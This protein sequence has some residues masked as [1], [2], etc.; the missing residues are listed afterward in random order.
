MLR[1]GHENL[2]VS[3]LEASIR[4][5]EE[6]FGLSLMK[7]LQAGAGLMAWLGD[8]STRDFFLELTEGLRHRAAAI[9]PLL[10][11]AGNCGMPNIVRR[12]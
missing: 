11:S 10:R 3:N 1:F 7:R 8:G 12:A 4:F 6:M 5:Y 9:S 2:C